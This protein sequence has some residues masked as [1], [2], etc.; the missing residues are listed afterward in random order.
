MSMFKN[1]NLGALGFKKSFYE[2]IE[3]A[4]IGGFEG[5][6]LSISEISDILCSTLLKE[7][8]SLIKENGLKL[9]GWGLPINILGKKEKYEKDLERL[10]FFASIAESLNCLRVYTWI[11]PYSDTLPYKENFDFHVDRFI[12]I[13]EILE[14]Y[15]CSLGLEFVAPKTLRSNHKYEFIHTIDGIFEIIDAIGK[16]NLGL[17]LDSWHWYT[18]HGTMEQ[19]NSLSD[20]DVVYVHINDAPAGIDVDEQIDSVRKLPGDSGV[21]D[22]E[23]FLG[24]LHSIHYEGPVT[25]EPF[26]KKLLDITVEEAVKKVCGSL[27]KIW[28]KN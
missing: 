6:D 15:R 22:L 27:N 13:A 1:L 28:L 26:E 11:M 7:V 9:G 25:P 2:S 17:L 4:N 14:K 8:K 19:I 18:S 21:I 24:S 10:S 3:L 5:I 16:R 20:K 23:G 12:P